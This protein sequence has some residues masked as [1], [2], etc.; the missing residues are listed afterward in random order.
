[1]DDVA[2]GVVDLELVGRDVERRL[3][4]RLVLEDEVLGGRQRRDL[5]GRGRPA[6]ALAARDLEP[7]L[8]LRR[9]RDDL[10]VVGRRRRVLDPRDLVLLAGLERR[11]LLADR[12]AVARRW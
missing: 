3:V 2:V 12:L 9:T 1:V 5:A 10:R 7:E 11:E 4:D 8:A 6:L